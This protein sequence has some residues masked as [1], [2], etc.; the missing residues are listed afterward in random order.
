MIFSCSKGMF[1]ESTGPHYVPEPAGS[2]WGDSGAT[3]SSVA[4]RLQAKFN[5][6]TGDS[7]HHDL[8]VV[9]LD[10][11]VR[12]VEEHT[13]RELTFEE[14]R[15]KVFAGFVVAGAG[16]GGTPTASERALLRHGHPLAYFETLI[17]WQRVLQ[18]DGEGLRETQRVRRPTLGRQFAPSWSWAA[19]GTKVR[20][21]HRG[22]KESSWQQMV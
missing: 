8:N 12:A 22:G 19:A 5:S 9:S 13:A 20:F 21:L 17:T 11:Y 3:P 6:A 16:A 15:V 10:D 1:R 18:Y 14:D 7:H 4:S 2:T